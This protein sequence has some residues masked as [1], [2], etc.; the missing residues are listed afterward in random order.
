MKVLYLHSQCENGGIS[1]IVFSLCDLLA[2]DGSE[3]RFFFSRGFVPS[4]REKNCCMFG[5]MFEVRMHVLL[6]RVFD[7][8]AFHSNKA[9]RE[10]IKLISDYSPDIIHLNN[11][12][13]Y[14][15]NIEL[16]FNFLK[17][18]GI[19]IV[20]TFHDC[21]NLT[22]HCSHFEYYGCDDWKNND[23]RSCKHKDVYPKSWIKCN[24]YKNFLRKK[25]LFT[26][27]EDLHIVVPSKWLAG[28]VSMSFFKNYPCRVINNGINLQSFDIQTN[29]PQLAHPYRQKKIILAV[30]SV[31]TDRKGYS[32][33]IRLA[34]IIDRDEYCIAV[35]GLTEKQSREL[36]KRNIITILHTKSVKELAEWYSCAHVFIN[37]TYED[38][39]PTV[40]LEALACGT[41]VI[42]YKTGGSTEMIED[43]C[44]VVVNKGDVNS[45][46]KAIQNI[47]KNTSACRNVA[48]HYSAQERLFE[49]INLYKEIVKEK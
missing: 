9:T 33:I 14:Y 19:P 45:M 4:E 7:S 24:S 1:R 47:E 31:W 30:A 13:G 11:V 12:H 3:G 15:L 8:H 26:G 20:W 43:S 25:Q 27:I 49:Y 35:V 44:G 39:F 36:K 22:G 37:P 40:N 10:L 17:M 2:A 29:I 23:C 32:D 41:P 28:I 5:N 21:W 42:T 18:S 16:L 34:D 38:T 46:Y 48:E 6:S